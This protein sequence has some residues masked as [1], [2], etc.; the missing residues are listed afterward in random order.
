MTLV[1]VLVFVG[2]FL[3]ASFLFLHGRT[4]WRKRPAGVAVFVMAVVTC[5]VLTLA[6]LRTTFGI[7][8]P[9]WVRAIA[10]G[11]IIVGLAW[12]NIT[13]LRYEYSDVGGPT[14]TLNPGSRLSDREESR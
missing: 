8:I 6:M 12:K 2:W 10:F 3:S 5:G 14:A 9:D 1:G 4:P 11:L 7:M 13:I